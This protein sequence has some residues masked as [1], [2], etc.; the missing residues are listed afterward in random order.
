MKKILIFLVVF[1]FI[2]CGANSVVAKT[3]LSI[4]D[5]D[6]TFSKETFFEG[7]TI[8]IFARVLNVG[9]TDVYG[10]VVFFSNKKEIGNLQP[11]SIKV[12]TYDDVFINWTF[13]SGNYNIEAKIT[14]LDSTDDNPGNNQTGQKNIFVDLDSDN[15]QIGNQD[16]PDD[17]N[18]GLTDEREEIL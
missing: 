15:D 9:D 1:G 3:D 5:S 14:G 17:D 18:D 2:I 16:D 10:Q 7:E 6:I 12:G 8:R 13:K 4:S 11:I